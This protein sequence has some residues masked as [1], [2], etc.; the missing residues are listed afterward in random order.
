LMGWKDNW[1]R[2]G[3]DGKEMADGPRYRMCGNGV[4]GPVSAW[5]A[6]R[7]AMVTSGALLEAM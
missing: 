7:I 2:Y 1:T 3:H 4:V 5:L 6:R